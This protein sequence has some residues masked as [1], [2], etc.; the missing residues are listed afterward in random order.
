MDEMAQ[1]EREV[2]RWLILMALNQTNPSPC[3]ESLLR[4]LL[5]T[6]GLEFSERDVRRDL[7]YLRLRELVT[8]R[9]GDD[10]PMWLASITR[11]GVDLV[12]YTV[13]CEPGIARPPRY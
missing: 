1:A 9:R 7:D 5:R 8:L 6:Q 12:E 3:G 10:V 11:A 13:P 4:T 2:A